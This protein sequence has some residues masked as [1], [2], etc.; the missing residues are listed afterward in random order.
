MH[1]D[2]P[3]ETLQAVAVEESSLVAPEVTEAAPQQDTMDY[4]E[5]AAPVAREGSRERERSRSVRA[6]PPPPRRE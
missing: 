4:Q 1:A 2:E 5:E 3:E 6:S